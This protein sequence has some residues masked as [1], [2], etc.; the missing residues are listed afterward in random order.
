MAPANNFVQNISLEALPTNLLGIALIALLFAALTSFSKLLILMSAVA[1]GLGTPRLPGTIVVLSASALLTATIMWPVWSAPA[2]PT[3]PT[4]TT[5]PQSPPRGELETLLLS[6]EAFF[7]AN[8]SPA[9]LDFFRTHHARTLTPSTSPSTTTSTTPPALLAPSA[10]VLT[11]SGPAF[12][13]TELSEAMIGALFIIL[14]FIVIDLVVANFLLA[15][16][17]PAL[18]PASV[19]LPIKLL[20]FVAMGGW[21]LIFNGALMGYV[22]PA[23]GAG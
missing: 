22:Y 16:G 21:M 4:T 19:A 9:N 18:S 10:Q 12:M 6:H 17:T 23:G 3:S 8:A 11:I 5:A 2:P 15:L 7:L 14:P 13:L 1:Y 20:V